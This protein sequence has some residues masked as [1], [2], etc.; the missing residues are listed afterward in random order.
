MSTY[1]GNTPIVGRGNADPAVLDAWIARMGRQ[2]A[3]TYAPDRIYQAPPPGIGAAI[4]EFC[5]LWGPDPYMVTAQIVKECAGWQSRIVRDKNNPSGLGA[6]NSDPYNGAVTFATPR[7]GIRATVA[8]LMVYA[9]G[10]GPWAAFDPRYQAVRSAGWLGIA[11]VWRDLNG[12]WASPGIGYGESIANQANQIV[13]FAETE[14]PMAAQIP[15][16]AWVAARDDHYTKG[17]SQRIRGG[18]QHYSAGT[19]SLDWL[20]WSSGENPPDPDRRVSATFLIKR[21]ATLANRGWQL[22]RIEDTPWTTAFANAYTVSIE[23]EHLANQNI[24]DGDYVV[25]AQTWIDAAAYVREHNLGEIPLN[26]SGIRGHKEWVNN[27]GLI[28]PDGIELDRLVAEIA[29]LQGAPPPPPEPDFEL[30]T[31]PGYGTMTV[32][33]LFRLKW[34]ETDREKG[35][36]LPL[37]EEVMWFS[38]DVGHEILV[39]WY[40]RARFELH[41]GQVLLGRIGAE[42]LAAPAGG[43]MPPVDLEL[44]G[45]VAAHQREIAQH[46]LRIL[47]LT[48]TDL[49]LVTAHEDD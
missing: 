4:I 38:P 40:E 12:R 15:G 45:V 14:L 46:G 48:E 37:S 17:R 1:S 34:N 47:E 20:T 41:A 8:H 6:I 28:C 36:G 27:P 33:G 44:Y 18:A 9:A 35:S 3:P 43:G 31:V 2:L 19:N 24:P 32:K 25:V 13:A 29:R 42:L 5:D 22:V 7:E 30:I 21:N 23:Y 26:R 49:E 10:D 16:F 11:H 39:Q